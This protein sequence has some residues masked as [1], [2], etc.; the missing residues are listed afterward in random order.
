M[1]KSIKD[2]ALQRYDGADD[3][4]AFYMGKININGKQH[5]ALA[6]I[7]K[8]VEIHSWANYIVLFA[9]NCMVLNAIHWQ[10]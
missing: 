3:L 9:G 5:L 8:G 7:L 1:I 4:E 6:K 10:I 2:C